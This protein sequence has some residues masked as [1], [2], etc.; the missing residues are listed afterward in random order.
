VTVLM[1]WLVMQPAL[2]LGVASAKTPNPAGARVKS[3]ATHTV[4]GLGLYLS[5]LVLAALLF[6]GGVTAR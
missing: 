1:P 5:A 6:P 4:F 3:L 2:G